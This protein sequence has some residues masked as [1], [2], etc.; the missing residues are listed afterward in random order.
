MFHRSIS[1]SIAQSHSWD[2]HKV[3]HLHFKLIDCFLHSVLNYQ[4]IISSALGTTTII[5][6]P[7]EWLYKCL[8]NCKN[9]IFNSDCPKRLLVTDCL[10][11]KK[12]EIRYKVKRVLFRKL[13]TQ[14]WI[15]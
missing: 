15:S 7:S 1:A 10:A 11:N 4:S 14:K 9:F 6:S 5:F 2:A 13:V 12:K 8:S 3:Y